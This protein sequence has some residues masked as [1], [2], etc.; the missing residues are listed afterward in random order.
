MHFLTLLAVVTSAV[1]TAANPI[2]RRH[3]GGV[4]ICNGPHATGNCTYEVYNINQCYNVSA[5]FYQNAA[6]FA[7]DGEEFYCYPYIMDCGGICTS[8]EGCTLGG[9]S[10]N[11]TNRFNLTAFEGWDHY[12]SS[13]TCHT[14]HAQFSV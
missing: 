5:P 9:V 4:L 10:Y 12:I 8:P 14:G 3:V 2:E 6:T 13:F 1:I 7:P 11:T